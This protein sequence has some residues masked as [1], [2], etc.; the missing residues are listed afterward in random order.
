[1][2]RTPLGTKYIFLGLQNEKS[3]TVVNVRKPFIMDCPRI[4]FSNQVFIEPLHC[5]VSRE[6]GEVM[7]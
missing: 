3:I 5:S 7:H 4:S 2:Q 1:M 6:S